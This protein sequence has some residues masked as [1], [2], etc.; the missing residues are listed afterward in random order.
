MERFQRV[1]QCV[2]KCGH[3]GIVSEGVGDF[4]DAIHCYTQALI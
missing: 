4:V 1:I 2:Y 3:V